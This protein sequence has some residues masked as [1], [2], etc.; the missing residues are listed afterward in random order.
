M[1]SR[2]YLLEELPATYGKL[3]GFCTDLFLG[4]QIRKASELKMFREAQMYMVLRQA[5]RRSQRNKAPW[6]SK[7]AQFNMDL[8]LTISRAKQMSDEA[9]LLV[10]YKKKIID[11]SH[12]IRENV[13][14]G[15][16]P[17]LGPEESEDNS[18][19]S[20]HNNWADSEAHLSSEDP[21]CSS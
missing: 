21:L 16:G 19:L 9:I 13:W 11:G 5:F 8:A 14:I 4:E 10:D 3:Q 7:V 6:P 20:T 17:F 18:T 2:L 12:E 15:P 1:E